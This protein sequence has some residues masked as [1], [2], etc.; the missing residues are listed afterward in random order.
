[1]VFFQILL[2]DFAFQVWKEFPD[3]IVGYP[4]RE[5]FYDKIKNRWSY[6]SKYTNEYSMVLTGAAVYHR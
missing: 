2:I 4:A 6:T 5:H 3:R 1:M